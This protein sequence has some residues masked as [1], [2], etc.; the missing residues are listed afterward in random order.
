MNLKS[1][2]KPIKRKNKLIFLIILLCITISSIMIYSIINNFNKDKVISTTV[3]AERLSKISEL[4]TTKYSYSNIIALTDSKK[5]KD[6][7]IPFTEKSFLIK[8]SGYIKAGVDLK[9]LDIVVLQKNITITLK[10]SKI[11]DHVIN[12][13]DFFVYDEKSSM[14]NKLSIQDMI[15][16]ISNQKNKV[17]GDLIKTG[18]LEGANANAKL[19]LQGILW[20]MGF[21]N[22]T[23]I[24]K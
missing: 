21:E 10:K 7:H 12:N 13:E 14:F 15:N 11:L 3:I 1:A 16:E 9:D 24:F 2:F 6:F 5:I 20:D 22:V 18:F 8:Y 17:E 19:L 23:I 4:S